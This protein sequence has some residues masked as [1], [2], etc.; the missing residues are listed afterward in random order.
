MGTTAARQAW[1]ILSNVQKVLG[2]ELFAATQAIW[3]RGEEKL[4]PATR[5]VYDMVRKEVFPI[6]KDVV[7]HEE[8]VKFQKM[9]Q[10]HRV[11]AAAEGV[12]GELA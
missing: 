9:V 3:M 5:G 2:I 8:M 10:E 7:M 12:C 6:T 1:E 4:A 11:S